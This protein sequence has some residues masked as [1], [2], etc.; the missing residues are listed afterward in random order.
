M[1]MV[2]TLT[3]EQNTIGIEPGEYSVYGLDR[4]GSYFLLSPTGKISLVDEGS[5]MW[6]SLEHTED[7][8]NGVLSCQEVEIDSGKHEYLIDIHNN[9]I[10][11][12]EKMH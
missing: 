11:K 3:V 2:D 12:I 7:C 10:T 9:Q 8:S 5:A 6:G 4:A 1:A